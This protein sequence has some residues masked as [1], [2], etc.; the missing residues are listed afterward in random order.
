MLTLASLR[1]LRLG[2]AVNVEKII[3]NSLPAKD[4]PP[5]NIASWIKQCAAVGREDLGQKI[6]DGWNH[7]LEKHSAEIFRGK[8]WP[9]ATVLGGNSVKKNVFGKQ[10]FVVWLASQTA[11]AGQPLEPE[12]VK[13]AK[14][15][16]K[17]PPVEATG[18]GVPKPNETMEDWA[19]AA[20]KTRQTLDEAMSA[21][22]DVESYMKNMLL[23]QIADLEKK[24]AQ[25]GPGGAKEKTKDGEPSKMSVRVPKWQSELQVYKTKMDEVSKQVAD[26]KVKFEE[27]KTAY[28]ADAPMSVGLENAMQ[29]SIEKMM[30]VILNM[31]DLEKQREMLVKFSAMLDKQKTAASLNLVEAGVF[32]SVIDFFKKIGE[33]LKSLVKWAASMVKVTDNFEMTATKL[34]R[35]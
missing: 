7:C 6:M 22:A 23:P 29:A 1:S 3:A 19:E 13:E 27:A 28:K 26:S 2:D 35:K 16:S 32:E 14:E 20:K 8:A 18:V 21:F 10:E 25:Y 33:G 30:E 4:Y 31:K 12:Q 15:L 34:G 5:A 17:P 11:V 9:C 24:I